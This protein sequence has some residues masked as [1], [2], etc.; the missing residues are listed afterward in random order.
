MSLGNPKNYTNAAASDLGLNAGLGADQSTLD[1]D[2]EKKKRLM[3]QQREKLGL[4][5]TS[6]YGMAAMSIFGEPNGQ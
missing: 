3:Q 6:V 2:E 5:G 4:S 1:D